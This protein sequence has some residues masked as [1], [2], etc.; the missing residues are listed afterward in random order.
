M[1]RGR[2]R[3]REPEREEGEA[4]WLTK[5]LLCQFQAD[6]KPC[7]SKYP[8]VLASQAAYQVGPQFLISWRKIEKGRDDSFVSQ[9]CR[10]LP[11]CWY[12]CGFLSYF[13]H[14]QSLYTQKPNLNHPFVSQGSFFPVPSF[15][16]KCKILTSLF[17][18]HSFPLE[19]DGEEK[20]SQM[21]PQTALGIIFV[22]IQQ[23]SVHHAPQ[24]PRPKCILGV[25]FRKERN[26]IKKKSV[27]LQAGV[28]NHWEL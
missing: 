17:L 12:L 16:H 23:L 18:I 9:H 4:V 10:Y 19:W 21:E 15:C 20:S 24:S 5:G 6:L 27:F 2:G 25:S 1:E 22:C 8:A 13:V 7:F 3:E 14:F 26:S 28:H 11:E